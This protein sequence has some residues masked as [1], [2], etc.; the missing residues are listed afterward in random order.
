MAAS[1]G[2][3]SLPVGSGICSGVTGAITDP[4]GTVARAATDTVGKWLVEGVSGAGEK[5]IDGL[6]H[7]ITAST[8]PNLG[9]SWF[10]SN[11]N[12]VLGIAL[13]VAAVTFIMQIATSLVRRE[14]GMLTRAVTGSAVGVVG[15]FV[16]LSICQACLIGTDELCTGLLNASGS[17]SL[18]TSLNTI[19]G[20]SMLALG[21][22][23]WLLA[24]VLGLLFIIA[25]V[26]LWIAMFLREISI[27]V[28]AVFAP[29]AFAGYGWDRTRSWLRRWGEI[30]AALVFSKLVIYVIFILGMAM[31]SSAGSAGGLAAAI[32]QLLGGA[33]LVFMASISPWATH[34]FI[35]FAGNASGDAHEHGSPRGA[36]GAAAITGVTAAMVVGRK[37][38]N[39][40]GG[41]V[42]GGPAGA[43]AGAAQPAGGGEVAHQ[44]AD[45][46]AP[47]APPGNSGGS[48]DS[49]GGTEPA[50]GSSPAP[51]T[52][53]DTGG[54]GSG[55]SPGA[56]AG[57]PDD[58]GAGGRGESAPVPVG[59]SAASASG[60]EPVS[61]PSSGGAATGSGG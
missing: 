10:L 30:V 60:P 58:G 52:P 40:I 61:G 13:V 32:T 5:L 33:C 15:G 12:V 19:W 48:G 6:D 54:S 53:A 37:V 25:A 46:G 4:A 2:C 20:G 36:V 43:A 59:A 55:G 16:I 9:A 18:G 49:G 39:T 57:S 28:L 35:S 51:S 11:Y 38:S 21:P 24:I 44:A 8:S 14:P 42:V 22:A 41:G 45:A 17:G 26:M 1:I 31:I 56:E 27:Y 7:L 47:S 34:R 3:D 50:P 29:I 23:Q